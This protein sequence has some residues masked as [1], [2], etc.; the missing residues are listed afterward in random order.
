M[1]HGPVLSNLYDLIKG[2]NRDKQNQ[3]YWDSRFS[4]DGDDL[5]ANFD[6]YPE[7]KLSRAE[8][9][10]ID[11]ID[12]QF[13]QNW[14]G[15]LIDYTHANCPEWHNPGATSIPISLANILN[16]LGRTQEDIDWILEETRAFQEEDRIFASLVVEE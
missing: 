11:K 4:T 9:A 16:A 1:K 5:L 14:Y 12:G 3:M 7:G 15:E 2:K 8:K 13:H 10:I 6:Q